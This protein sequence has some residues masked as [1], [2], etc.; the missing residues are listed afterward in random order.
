M[1]GATTIIT[2]GGQ[3]QALESLAGATPENET[4]MIVGSN[5]LRTRR[6][7]VNWAVICLIDQI[8]REH[9]VRTAWAKQFPL[10]PDGLYLAKLHGEAREALTE[11]VARSAP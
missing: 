5:T 3:A 10:D 11:A 1:D 8:Q 7:P 4:R 6:T 2:V 9:M